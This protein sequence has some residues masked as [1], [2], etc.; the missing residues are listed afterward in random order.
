MISSLL[1][2]VGTVD[3]IFGFLT[4]TKSEFEEN[5]DRLKKGEGRELLYSEGSMT[6]LL[7]KFIIEPKIVVTDSLKGNENVEKVIQ[8]CLE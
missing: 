8:W 3:K 6:K 5:I 7:S 2:T 4:R 1:G